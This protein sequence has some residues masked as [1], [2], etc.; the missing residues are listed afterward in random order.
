MK[1]V[2][3]PA[4]LSGQSLICSASIWAATTDVGEMSRF[5]ERRSEGILTSSSLTNFEKLRDKS[6]VKQNVPPS[7]HP[8][9]REH[10]E[11]PRSTH[12]QCR[13]SCA[14]GNAAQGV[15]DAT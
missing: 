2:S 1:A 10:P 15:D 6:P 4:S 14:A 11:S 12:L 5:G 8:T 7:L 9:A 13:W 3:M